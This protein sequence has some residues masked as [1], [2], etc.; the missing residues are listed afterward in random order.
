MP[1]STLVA[2]A[3]TADCVRVE[4]SHRISV[5]AVDLKAIADVHIAVVPGLRRGLPRSIDDVTVEGEAHRSQSLRDARDHV[6][7]GVACAVAC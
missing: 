2:R 6:G 1:K 7:Q 5:D 4:G 3:P